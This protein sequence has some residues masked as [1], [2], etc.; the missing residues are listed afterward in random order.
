MVYFSVYILNGPTLGLISPVLGI[1]YKVSI[2]VMLTK[3][4]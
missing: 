1:L 2:S 4:C 3:E